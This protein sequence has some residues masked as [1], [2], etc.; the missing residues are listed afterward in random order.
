MHAPRAPLGARGV[1]MGVMIEGGL[2]LSPVGI[3]LYFL[4]VTLWSAVVAYV[5]IFGN[6]GA[7]E[8]GEHAHHAQT[9]PAH[10]TAHEAPVEPT[11]AKPFRGF[12]PYEGFKSYAQGE[13]VTVEDIV[14]GIL[15]E[16]QAAPSSLPYMPAPVED[17]KLSSITKTSPPEVNVFLE[18]IAHAE[19]D[20]A[21]DF[22]RDIEEKGETDAFFMSAH[23]AVDALITARIEGSASDVRTREIFASTDTEKLHLLRDALATGKGGKNSAKLALTR[24]LSALS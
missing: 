16:S 24:A 3:T 8:S 11:R 5:I 22:L 18:L 15:R 20:S 23:D 7:K 6:Q 4:V 14:K 17:I 19:R 1:I 13:T 2:A 9:A 21:Q 10:H 12:S